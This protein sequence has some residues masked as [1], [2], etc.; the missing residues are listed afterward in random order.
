MPENNNIMSLEGQ[1]VGM[2]LAGP[3]SFT[4]QQLAYLKRALGV[5]ETV[6][7]EGAASK[8]TVSLSESPMNFEYIAVYAQAKNP[9][10]SDGF[11]YGNFGQFYNKILSSTLKNQGAFVDFVHMDG[12]NTTTGFTWYTLSTKWSGA[13]TTTWTWCRSEL[14]G[15]SVNDWY[16]LCRIVGIHR[17][18][19]GN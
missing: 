3:E 6:L 2:P 1:L 15:S 11:Q 19:G 13:N 12:N 5:D 10:G 14:N 7:W 8:G 4:P 17:I 16:Y 18:S 9:T